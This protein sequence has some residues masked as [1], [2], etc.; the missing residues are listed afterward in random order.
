MQRVRGYISCS[1]A[2]PYDTLTRA[3]D[4]AHS[5]AALADA[6]CTEIVLGDTDG[7]ASVRRLEENVM[8]AWGENVWCKV[9]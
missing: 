1:F 2:C 4:V 6:G 3:K 7:R 5:A 9:L 8:S